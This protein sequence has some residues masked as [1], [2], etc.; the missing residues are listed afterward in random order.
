MA[1]DEDV[2]MIEDEDVIM[3]EDDNLMRVDNNQDESSEEDCVLS[4]DSDYDSDCSENF[5]EMTQRDLDR[6]EINTINIV[7]KM[8][9]IYF[10]YHAEG[11]VKFCICCFLQI[12]D[13]FSRIRTM[14]EHETT[15]YALIFGLYC[16]E[17][18]NSL[19]QI[20]LCDMCPFAQIKLLIIYKHLKV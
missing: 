19:H 14:R 12:S 6:A 2:I 20:L 10:Y 18:R 8:C 4:G 9:C 3:I 1:E 5:A 17:C 13:L 16:K 15:S 11:N 7:K